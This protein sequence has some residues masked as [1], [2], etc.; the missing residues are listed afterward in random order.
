VASSPWLKLGFGL[1][2]R[3]IAP[4]ALVFGYLALSTACPVIASVKTLAVGGD[5][6]SFCFYFCFFSFVITLN[7]HVC[8]IFFV[9]SMVLKIDPS[10][11]SLGKK[12]YKGMLIPTDELRTPSDTNNRS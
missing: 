3:L 5:P 4:D 6:P 7:I 10:D 1:V 11:G 8:M 2:F 12:R 9:F